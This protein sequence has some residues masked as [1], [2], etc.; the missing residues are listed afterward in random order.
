MLGLG[1]YR[2]GLHETSVHAYMYSLRSIDELTA[3]VEKIQAMRSIYRPTDQ[4]KALLLQQ[5]KSFEPDIAF[6]HK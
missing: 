2:R 4:H 6:H 5:W 3:I 1:A